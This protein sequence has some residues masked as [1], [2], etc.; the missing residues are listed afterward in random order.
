MTAINTTAGERVRSLAQTIAVTDPPTASV[1]KPNVQI[2]NMLPPVIVTSPPD[3]G[4]QTLHVVKQGQTVTFGQIVTSSE[5]P[6]RDFAIAHAVGGGRPAVIGKATIRLSLQGVDAASTDGGGQIESTP[7]ETEAPLRTANID[8]LR[9]ADTASDD[10]LSGTKGSETAAVRISLA[11][12]VSP[13][14]IAMMMG[15]QPQRSDLM[16]ALFAAGILLPSA[17][18]QAKA[19]SAHGDEKRASQARSMCTFDSDTDRL[20]PESAETPASFDLPS[21]IGSAAASDEDEWVYITMDA[22]E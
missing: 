16:Q 21:V 19:R 17:T 5:V 18:K 15:A 4:S 20:V 13:E 12:N 22:A 10:L 2:G 9:L 11:Q 14:Q 3:S 6:T 1:A 7:V 8:A